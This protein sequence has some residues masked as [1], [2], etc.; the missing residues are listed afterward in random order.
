[1]ADMADLADVANMA[2]MAVTA[3]TPEEVPRCPRCGTIAGGTAA[4]LDAL[5]GEVARLRQI[6]ERPRADQDA[7]DDLALALKEAAAREA[8]LLRQI[9][10]LQETVARL[11]GKIVILQRLDMLITRPTMIRHFLTKGAG[12]A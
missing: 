3:V 6:A 12:V 11:R 5:Y 4:A 2:N 10:L 1:M 9:R 7:D 8:E